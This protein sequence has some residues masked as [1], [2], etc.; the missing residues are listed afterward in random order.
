[1]RRPSAGHDQPVVTPAM[2]DYLKAIRR[3]R[4]GAAAVSTKRLSVELGVSGPSV[5][6]M[7][8][9]LDKLGLLH[10]RR[11]RGVVLTEAGERIAI[12][13]E[14]RHT[15]ISR[16]LSEV[17]GVPKAVVDVEAEHLEHHISVELEPWLLAALRTE[18]SP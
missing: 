3:A 16:Y 13:V 7:V 4:S 6:N 9:R 17:V 11:H 15:I 10:H 2:E 18:S 1:M 14:Q 8:K 5:T 12:G